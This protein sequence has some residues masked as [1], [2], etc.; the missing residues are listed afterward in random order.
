MSQTRAEKQTSQPKLT[1]SFVLPSQP[2]VS[3]EITKEIIYLLL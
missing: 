1:D 2:Y 3:K